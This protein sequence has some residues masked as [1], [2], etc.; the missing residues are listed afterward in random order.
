MLNKYLRL[1]VTIFLFSCDEDFEFPNLSYEK[2]DITKIDKV[3]IIGNSITFHAPALELGWTGNWGMAATSLQNDYVHLLEAEL[4]SV[5]EMIQLQY[6]NSSG[7]EAMF[8]KFE[9]DTFNSLRDYEADL[10]IINLGENVNEQDASNHHF[11]NSLGDLIKF[12]DKSGNAEVVCV[13]SFWNKD[14]VNKQI[15]ELCM[16]QEYRFVHISDLSE[17][18]QFTALGKFENPEVAA[19]PSDLGMEKIANRILE[20]LGLR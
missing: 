9:L 20:V 15:F 16:D 7:F 2:I 8:W 10:I 13:D 6:D 11:G 3:L 18:K 4:L 5:Q 19:H 12:L 17:N 1:L 14:V